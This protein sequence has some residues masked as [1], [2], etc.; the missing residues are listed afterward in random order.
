[1]RDKVTRRCPQTTTFEEKGEPKWI[2]AEVLLLTSLTPYSSAT[3]ANIS[4]VKLIAL[5]SHCRRCAG[6][7]SASRPVQSDADYSR[8]PVESACLCCTAWRFD[9]W[10]TVVTVTATGLCTI[11]LFCNQ[12]MLKVRCTCCGRLQVALSVVTFRGAGHTQ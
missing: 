3:P 2:R 11:C 5:F 4:T 12:D 1:M 6:H 10:P 9:C 7:R 8:S